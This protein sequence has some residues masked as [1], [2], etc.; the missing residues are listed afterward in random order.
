MDANLALGLAGLLT[1]AFLGGALMR[2]PPMEAL[3]PWLQ[4]SLVSA[5]LWTLG[6]IFAVQATTI[7]SKRLALLLLYGGAMFLPALWLVVVFRWVGLHS[8]RL[9]RVQS[10]FQRIPLWISGAFFAVLLAQPWH[11][12][13]VEPVVGTRN[14]YGTLFPWMLL[15]GYLEVAVAVSLAIAVARTHP[16]TEV[17]R[18]GLFMAFAPVMPL[19][20][21][22]GY[23]MTDVYEPSRLTGLFLATSCLAAAGA[24]WGARDFWLLPVAIR[25]V[26]ASDSSG[27]VVLGRKGRASWWNPAASHL[28]GEAAFATD[29]TL[30]S[31][32]LRQVRVVD[33]LPPLDGEGLAGLVA[34]AGPAGVVA[35]SV[36]EPGRYLRLCLHPIRRRG[37]PAAA[38]L[39]IEDVSERVRVER[40]RLALSSERLEAEKLRHLARVASDLADGFNARLSAIVGA[41]FIASAEEDRGGT[42]RDHL[43]RIAGEADEALDLTQQLLAIAGRSS[44]VSATTSALSLVEETIAKLE[45]EESGTLCVASYVAPALPL[46]RADSG[47]VVQGLYALARSARRRL[48]PEVAQLSLTA[49]IEQ[50]DAQAAG[51]YHPSLEPGHFVMISLVDEGR[52]MTESERERL[53]G[54]RAPAGATQADLELSAGVARLL[55]NGASLAGASLA[56]GSGGG[57]NVVRVAFPV[58]TELSSQDG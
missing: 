35:E 4:L 30:F 51:A 53:L 2:W 42:V 8:P 1:I 11:G 18:A 28:L 25:E 34:D 56:S 12:A 32:L 46:L 19:L 17:R 58:E 9:L 20:G 48:A 7:E 49:E 5:G 33:S 24:V 6:E 23:M 44:P 55:A 3:S 37:Q 54:R 45:E 43:A 10:D 40:L 26:V 14:E 36:P 57:G 41:A 22:V 16:S 47:Q 38:A 29:A 21:N 50:L 13:L 31:T 15:F 52:P 27:V 39:R